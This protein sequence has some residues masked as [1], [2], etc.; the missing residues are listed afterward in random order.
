MPASIS[1]P[2]AFDITKSNDLV[3]S[4][5]HPPFPPLHS[6]ASPVTPS[7]VPLTQEVLQRC[8]SWKEEEVQRCYPREEEEQC[9]QYQMEPDPGD[10]LQS[11]VEAVIHQG[12]PHRW[13]LRLAVEAVTHQDSLHH[14]GLRL[15]VVVRLGSQT[16]RE[17]SLLDYQTS[18]PSPGAFLPW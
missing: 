11:G 16:P 17:A 1:L 8:Y 4:C 6:H 14:W 3:Q 15:V 9:Y 18:F 10:Q 7:K 2:S 5:E 13:G 12:W